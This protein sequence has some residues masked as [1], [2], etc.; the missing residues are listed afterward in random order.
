MHTDLLKRYLLLLAAVHFSAAGQTST[1]STEALTIIGDFADR[2]CQTVP[3]ETTINE[4][5]LTGGAKAEL[6]G[7]LSKLTNL[8]VSG[9]AKYENI[10]SK[11]V[12]QKD[13]A[14]AIQDSRTCRLQIWKDL[15]DKF[16]IG[17]TASLPIPSPSP[18]AKHYTGKMGPLEYGL[19]YNQGDM[20][21]KPANSAEE[22]SNRCYN[23]DRCIAVTYVVDQNRCWLKKSIGPIG[24]SPQMIS[25]RKLAQ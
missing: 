12:L 10:E 15:K 20:Y 13:L 11:N 9:T 8:G 18:E 22:C 7:V 6:A 25:A 4:I 14:A 19:S 24:K 1:Q 17:G 16:Q 3:L 5:Q 21:D 2:L 23:D